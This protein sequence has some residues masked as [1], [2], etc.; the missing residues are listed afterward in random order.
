MSSFT[1]PYLLNAPYANLGS[2]VGFIY[3]CFSALAALYVFFFIPEL[4]NRSFEEVDILFHEKVKAI[5]SK[6]WKPSASIMQELDT[7]A[8]GTEPKLTGVE[9]KAFETQVEQA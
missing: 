2:K 5:G 8:H 4:K 6:K 9:E 7:I 3:G 1:V